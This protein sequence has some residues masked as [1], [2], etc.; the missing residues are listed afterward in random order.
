MKFQLD[1]L[2]R[3]KLIEDL[4]EASAIK[5]PC[6]LHA[7]SDFEL[8][9]MLFLCTKMNAAQYSAKYGVQ[10]KSVHNMTSRMR[11]QGFDYKKCRNIAS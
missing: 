2:K 10:V 3:S 4:T 8:F 1:I 5:N 9:K 11:K 6:I 7:V